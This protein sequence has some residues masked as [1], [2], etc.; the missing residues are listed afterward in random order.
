M[1]DSDHRIV[2]QCTYMHQMM[3]DACIT[4]Q[5]RLHKLQ[6]LQDIPEQDVSLA[7]DR[8]VKVGIGSHDLHLTIRFLPGLPCCPLC[9][10]A[11]CLVLCTVSC[12]VVCTVSCI[13]SEQGPFQ[14]DLVIIFL[15]YLVNVFMYISICICTYHKTS[16][17]DLVGWLTGCCATSSFV[18]VEHGTKGF[19]GTQPSCMCAQHQ[20]LDQSNHDIC[21]NGVTD[22]HGIPGVVEVM[23]IGHAGGVVKYLH[24]IL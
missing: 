8:Y 23:Q 11:A 6:A 7:D 4:N 18:F 2:M 16:L 17:C 19:A 24:W 3:R 5:R 15:G 13:S 22:S 14:I 1:H 10:H 20:A 9:R 12:T 21:T